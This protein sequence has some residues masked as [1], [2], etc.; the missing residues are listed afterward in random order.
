MVARRLLLTISTLPWVGRE[1][2]MCCLVGDPIRCPA[3]GNVRTVREAAAALCNAT[4]SGRVGCIGTTTRA[5][6][7]VAGTRATT[8]RRLAAVLGVDPEAFVS[9]DL[10]HEPVMLTTRGAASVLGVHPHTVRSWLV[11]GKLPGWKVGTRWRIAR[12]VVVDLPHSGRLRGTF[13]RI[14]RRDPQNRG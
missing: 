7:A 14:A 2:G 9:D 1:R 13:R 8:V 5:W 10:A 12:S 4:S 11:A 3:G 6:F